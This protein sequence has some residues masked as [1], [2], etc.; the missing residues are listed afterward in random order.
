MTD[1]LATWE[2][3]AHPREDH[4]GVMPHQRAGALMPTVTDRYLELTAE[5]NRLRGYLG[6]ACREIRGAASSREAL[7]RD[8]A[9]WRQM[10]DTG[11]GGIAMAQVWVDLYA[12][13]AIL[14]GNPQLRGIIEIGTWQGGFSGWLWAQARLRDMQFF[15][16]DA[17]RPERPIR[18]TGFCRVDVFATPEAIE[19]TIR[20]IGEPLM[21]LCD[22][23][24]KPRE[25]RTFAPMLKDPGSL[26]AVHDWGTETTAADVPD[27]LEPAYASYLEELGS[28]TR[29]FRRP[30]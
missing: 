14:N 7:E 19:D 11:F 6:D 16:C 15:T 18:Y 1:Q 10:T 20:S 13:E 17:V 3:A 27:G 28:I 2:E 26:I 30:A 24:N 12:W 29:F 22:G 25:L 21:L 5:V 23:G 4:A 9:R 8:H